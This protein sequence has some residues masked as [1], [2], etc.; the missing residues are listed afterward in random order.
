MDIPLNIISNDCF[1]ITLQWQSI[2][3]NNGVKMEEVISFTLINLNINKIKQLGV[4][5][6]TNKF[7]KNLSDSKIYISEDVQKQFSITSMKLPW[8]LVNIKK[9]LNDK[10]LFSFITRTLYKIILRVI[11]YYYYIESAELFKIM[12]DA[13]LDTPYEITMFEKLFYDKKK[14]ETNMIMEHI[15]ARLDISYNLNFQHFESLEEGVFS[16]ND[17]YVKL[18]AVSHFS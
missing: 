13:I 17:T 16:N 4:N 14:V 7:I 2:F 9:S 3:K 11:N 5:I 10:P 18:C 15:F 6:N 12:R 8:F 1:S